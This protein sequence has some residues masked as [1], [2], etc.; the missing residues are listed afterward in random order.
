M[1]HLRIKKV[2]GGRKGGQEQFGMI[3][4]CSNLQVEPFAHFV[5]NENKSSRCVKDMFYTQERH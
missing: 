2:I 4:L 1:C 3:N 5:F